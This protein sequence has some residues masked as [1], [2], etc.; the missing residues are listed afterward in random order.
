VAAWRSNGSIAT[1]I[2]N[3]L[4]HCYSACAPD[5]AC[6]CVVFDWPVDLGHA[7]GRNVACSCRY[8]GALI[9]KKTAVLT[10]DAVTAR[11]PRVV[12]SAAELTNSGG[13]D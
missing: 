9:Q 8:T 10:Q 7:P 6:S 11:A 12:M 4:G 13:K 5:A 1:L 3:E 2:G